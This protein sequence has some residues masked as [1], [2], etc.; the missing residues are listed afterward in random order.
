VTATQRTSAGAAAAVVAA[1]A[2]WGTTGTAQA[3][4]PED[5]DPTSVGALCIAVGALAL[6]LLALPALRRAGAGG[7]GQVR[8]S[9][10]RG[11]ATTCVTVVIGGLAVAAYQ[12]CFFLGVARAWVALG[13]V[14]ALGIARWRPGCSGCCSVNG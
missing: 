4:G 3:L 2:L 14:I 1:A 10:H 6:L 13:T 12:A 11:R 7:P 5:S 9:G 8:P